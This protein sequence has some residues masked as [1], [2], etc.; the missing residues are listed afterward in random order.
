MK[1][2]VQWVSVL[3]ENGTI[4]ILNKEEGHWISD[5]YYPAYRA[6][7]SQVYR[8]GRNYEIRAL[9]QELRRRR[10]KQPLSYPSGK[11]IC[12]TCWIYAGKLIQDAGLKG[13]RVEM[14]RYQNIPFYN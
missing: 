1:D 4:N 7:C 8:A 12:L 10:E 6:Y 2:V 3:D 9:I 5:Q 13:M 14:L 11:C